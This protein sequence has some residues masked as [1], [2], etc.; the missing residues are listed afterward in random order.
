MTVTVY[1]SVSYVTNHYLE[2]LDN[3]VKRRSS[4][5]EPVENSAFFSSEENLPF[6][7]QEEAGKLRLLFA[8]PW[9][10]AIYLCRQIYVMDQESLQQ[11]LETVPE[12]ELYHFNKETEEAVPITLSYTEEDD[13]YFL[14]LQNDVGKSVG[15]FFPHG[16]PD[17][18]SYIGGF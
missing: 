4:Y 3:I 1:G 11:N 14:L 2:K 10:L 13:C 16:N 5:L 7:S 17:D 15:A 8:E 9:V 18:D 12:D 6:M